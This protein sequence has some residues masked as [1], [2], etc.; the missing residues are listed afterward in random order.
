MTKSTEVISI[1]L[2]HG[3]HGDEL[4]YRL[5]RGTVLRLVPGS[6]LLG[7]H[8]ALYCNYPVTGK[9]DDFFFSFCNLEFTFDVFDILLQKKLNLYEINTYI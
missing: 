7:R 5:K 8:V 4:L 2:D 6:S 3:V 9:F 1:K